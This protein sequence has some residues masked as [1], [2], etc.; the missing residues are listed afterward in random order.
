MSTSVWRKTKHPREVWIQGGEQVALYP[1]VRNLLGKT[2]FEK[3]KA[4][5][6]KTKV[7]TLKDNFQSTLNQGAG[8]G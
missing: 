5:K 1:R 2:I 4:E 3:T 6:V 8:P 7:K